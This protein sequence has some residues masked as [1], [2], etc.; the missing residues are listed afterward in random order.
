MFVIRIL[1]SESLANFSGEMIDHAQSGYRVE[2][3]VE[4]QDGGIG[5]QR[6]SGDENILGW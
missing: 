4:R 6:V 3:Y 5:L 1:D 2:M